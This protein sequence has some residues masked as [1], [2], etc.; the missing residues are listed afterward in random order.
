MKVGVVAEGEGLDSLV[1]E[2]FGHAPFFLIVDLDSLD[3]NVVKNEYA[4]NESGAGYKVA[5]AIVS[6][7]VNAAVVGGIGPHG[8]DILRKA[9]IR[10]WSDMDDMT[11]EEALE[12]V[13]GRLTLEKKFEGKS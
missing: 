13:K 3:Y 10:V 8:M 2:D 12:S 5:D 4:D 1:A 6:L 9:G 11:V 7:K